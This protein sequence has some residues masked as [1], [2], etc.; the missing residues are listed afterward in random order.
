MYKIEY[1]DIFILHQIDEEIPDYFIW[2]TFRHKPQ[3]YKYHTTK[4]IL[5]RIGS[6]KK[7]FQSF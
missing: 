3:L 5:S 6:V 2:H 4:N 1:P 7:I